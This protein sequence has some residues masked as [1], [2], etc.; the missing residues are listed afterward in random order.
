[1][2]DYSITFACY[3]HAVY[4][5]QCVDSLV[6]H[7][8]D[9]SKV[10]AVDNASSDETPQYLQT[11]AT[12]RAHREQSQPGLRRGLE[13]GRAGLPVRVDGGDEQRRGSSPRAGSIHWSQPPTGWACGSSRPTLVEGLLDYDLDSFAADASS[14]MGGAVRMGG[15]Q[16]GVPVRASLGLGRSRLLRRDAGPVGL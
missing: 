2:T 5:R 15:R 11:P 3:N 6:R 12:R 4:T 16:C 8:V 7:G 14:R 9:L 13:P 10:A 1:M